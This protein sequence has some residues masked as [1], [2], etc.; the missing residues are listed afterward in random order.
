MIFYMTR[1]E[2]KAFPYI[3]VTP[4]PLKDS[5]VSSAPGKMISYFGYEFTVPWNTNFKE[6]APAGNGFV[7]LKFE[8]GTS[9][10]F[11]IATD[12][13]GLLSEIV[14][15]PKLNMKSLQ[16]GFPDLLKRSA[17]DQYDALYSV[18]PA[19]IHAFG[20]R[21]EATRGMLLLTLKLMAAPAGLES[22]MFRFEFPG[23]H[24]FQIGDPQKTNRTTLD[25]FDINGHN[26]EIS[27][28]T[29]DANRL[30]QPELNRILAT[31]HAAPPTPAASIAYIST[32]HN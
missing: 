14:K 3:N 7:A 29:R 26:V 28:F 32:P 8:S 1:R 19:S 21:V 10:T 11:Q 12:Q 30:S 4:Q 20:P 2:A 24:G 6:V 16:D 27:L 17:Y 25:I 22:G 18:T 15:D 9:M 23:M 13:D 5:S 31:L